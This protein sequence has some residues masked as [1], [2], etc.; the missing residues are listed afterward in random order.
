MLNTFQYP[1]SAE[2]VYSFKNTLESCCSNSL[3]A[4][5]W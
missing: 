2:E 4:E 1:E 3:Y 5:A